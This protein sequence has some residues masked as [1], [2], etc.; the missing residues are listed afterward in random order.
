[1]YLKG[2]PYS[3]AMDRGFSFFPIQL[4]RCPARLLPALNRLPVSRVTEWDFDRSAF[5]RKG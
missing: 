2:I 3:R 1:M 5:E 4:N